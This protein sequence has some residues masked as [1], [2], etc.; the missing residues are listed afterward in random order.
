MHAYV[1][2]YMYKC[3][4]MNIYVPLALWIKTGVQSQVAS[5]QRLKKWYL[6]APCLTLSITRLRI[7]GK[8]GQSRETSSALLYARCRS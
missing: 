4:Y 1:Y 7:K 6:M 5:Y 8:F 3:I 2:M